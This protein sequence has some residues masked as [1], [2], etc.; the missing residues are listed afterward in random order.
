[1]IR[2][3]CPSCRKSL[4]A[5]ADK[6][7]ARCSCPRC[8]SR[9][10][11]PAIK[12][13]TELADGEASTWLPVPVNRSPDSIPWATLADSDAEGVDAV[14]ITI[15]CANC[16]QRLRV[17][18]DKIGVMGRCPKCRTYFKVERGQDG[19]LAV[20]S[21]VG[22]ALPEEKSQGQSPGRTLV[23]E[24]QP[25]RLPLLTRT[26]AVVE[27]PT[28]KCVLRVREDLFNTEC[29]CS[30]CSG[31]FIVVVPERGTIPFDCP[32]CGHEMMI[33][34]HMAGR[35]TRCR[36][37]DGVLTVPA[38]RVLVRRLKHSTITR[39][40]SS[41][42]EFVAAAAGALLLGALLSGSGTGGRTC[43]SCGR[44]IRNPS[45]FCYKCRPY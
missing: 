28:C 2:F 44:Y 39:Q 31:L 20:M 43:L 19:K 22:G 35:K 11:V 18:E 15:A 10:A 38:D 25:P 30:E 8:G 29:S 26:A 14:P 1:V 9:F 32:Y 34:E 33:R 7:G 42:G 6:P 45:M 21:L 16:S 40:E 36:D 3:Q 24:G 12:P 17:A 13:T 5:P 27:C 41:T 4:K 37:C 23:P